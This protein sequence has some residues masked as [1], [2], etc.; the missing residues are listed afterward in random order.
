MR[1]LRL[2]E[3]VARRRSTR[4][5]ARAPIGPATTVDRGVRA[6]DCLLG[7]PVLRLADDRA[8][9]RS[10]AIL[11]GGDLEQPARLAE[12][13]P[14]P[15]RRR[16]RGRAAG[17]RSGVADSEPD[18]QASAGR[19]RAR[20]ATESGAAGRSP[21]AATQDDGD[22]R[23]RRPWRTPRAPRPEPV[24]DRTAGRGRRGERR[25]GRGLPGATAIGPR[26]RDA[27]SIAGRDRVGERR[28]AAGQDCGPRPPRRSVPLA[29]T[30]NVALR[31][32][33][34]VRRRRDDAVR[35]A[36]QL[37]RH[38]RFAR[39]R[40]ARSPPRPGSPWRLAGR[41]TAPWATTRS[42]RRSGRSPIRSGC[43]PGRRRLDQRPRV[44]PRG[45]ARAP[46]RAPDG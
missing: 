44:P 30:I 14:A 45:G 4:S 10:L 36:P 41:A 27:P 9:R 33:R 8:I 25:A 15:R 37:E 32:H 5:G 43:S 3:P 12:V 26:C 39:R 1:R 38:R 28:P 18:E 34:P 19:S 7:R 11:D 23:R 31:A 20:A 16:H 21:S 13:A 40:S 17:C 2:V 6:R 46:R 35:P 42:T 29:S 24:V 22:R